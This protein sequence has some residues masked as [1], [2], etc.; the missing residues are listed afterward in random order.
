MK[1][2]TLYIATPVTHNES[3]VRN[4]QDLCIY[5]LGGFGGLLPQETF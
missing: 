4:T 5:K 3:G 2:V 1:F